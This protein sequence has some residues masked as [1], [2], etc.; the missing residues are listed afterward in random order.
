M[1]S[2]ETAERKLGR[3]QHQG[4]DEATD[5]VIGTRHLIALLLDGV[6]QR[7]IQS[8]RRSHLGA[9]D[10][11]L[12]DIQF[13][14]I[15]LF[16]EKI[17]DRPHVLRDHQA[18]LIGR[19]FRGVERV[20]AAVADAAGAL[21]VPAHVGH[22]HRVTGF[23]QS[24]GKVLEVVAALLQAV[25]QHDRDGFSAFSLFELIADGAG[26]VRQ[27]QL[28]AVVRATH[29][30][31]FQLRGRSRLLVFGLGFFLLGKGRR[32]NRRGEHR[33]HDR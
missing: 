17:L 20:V 14:G 12:V 28:Q 22:D 13:A 24:P 21:A 23:L 19:Q 7:E 25:Q 18:E 16:P 3:D 5:L 32:R 30:V 2:R 29:Q 10:A 1:H 9:D 11:E 31:V 8:D 15:V 6:D 33:N 26:V 4:L 27:R